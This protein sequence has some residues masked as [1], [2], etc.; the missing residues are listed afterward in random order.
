[1]V[2]WTTA[3]AAGAGW[4]AEPAVDEAFVAL[5]VNVLLA[6]TAVDCATAVVWFATAIAPPTAKNDVTLNPARRTRVAAAGWRR[7]A[8]L[9]GA[10]AGLD[11]PFA[12][13]DGLGRPDAARRSCSRR[14]RSA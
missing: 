10:V 11:E 5:P 6:G 8:F 12:V 14:R 2:V 7:R 1:V 13:A 3:L 4:A 9:A